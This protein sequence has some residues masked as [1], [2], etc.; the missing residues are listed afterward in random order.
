M[1]RTA[2]LGFMRRLDLPVQLR[3]VSVQPALPTVLDLQEPR[4]F[5]LYPGGSVPRIGIEIATFQGRRRLVSVD[6]ITGSPVS[7]VVP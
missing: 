5:L 2:D 4:T 1:S 3:I 7:A 6:P